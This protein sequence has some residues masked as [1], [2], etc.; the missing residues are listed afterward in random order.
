MRIAPFLISV[1]IT[2][3]LIY[4]LSRPW[5]AKVPMPIG[6]F[7][8]PQFGVWQNAEPSDCDFSGEL[9]LDGLKGKV[10]VVLDERLVPHVFAQ[11]DGDA[12]FIQGWLHARFRL[13]QM[14]FQTHAAA[15]RVS[16]IVGDRALSYDRT[17]RR[18]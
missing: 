9:V 11:D 17:K 5:G 7:L 15:G 4:A 16:E 1:M 10:E 6:K 18:L 14:E 13:W 8:S 3:G 2:G 12:S